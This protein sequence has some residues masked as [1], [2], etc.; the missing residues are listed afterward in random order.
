MSDVDNCLVNNS[1]CHYIDSDFTHK[2]CFE[3]NQ[4]NAT[5]FTSACLNIRSIVNKDHFNLF[6]SWIQSLQFLPDI[7]AIN[8]TWEKKSS[9]GQFRNLQH[10]EYISNFRS[11]LNGGGVALYIKKTI[12][13]A[14]RYD[15]SHMDEGIFESLF[16]DVQLGKDKI[17][18]STI[19]RS[20]KQD[21]FSNIQF[22]VQLNNV[23]NTINASKNKAY[24]MG[25][26]NYDL[27]QDSHTFTDNFVDTMYDHSFYPI[28]NKPTRITQNSSTCIDHIWTNIHDKIIKSA[29]ITHKIAD[30]LPVVQS[31]KIS[32]FKTALPKT[33]YFSKQNCARFIR[34]LSE[35]DPNETLNHTNVDDAMD[36]FMQQY[37]ILFN[38]HFPL[39]KKQSKNS[40]NSWFTNELRKLLKK[41]DR[42]YKK[43]IKNKSQANRQKYNVARNTYFHKIVSE[44]QNY[45]KNLFTIHKNDIKKTW[46]SINL[47]LGKEKKTVVL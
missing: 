47:L 14:L 46:H 34:A 42:M 3:N 44:K 8:E 43:Y 28:I 13:Y 39:M 9:I 18:C 1:L 24:I 26:L 21:K 10:Y 7:I 19:Y 11:N 33:R 31:T 40:S 32:N 23:L 38:L 29:I 27:L 30:H 35:I 6:E 37:S 36:S 17:T 15:L 12:H 20:P 4:T 2:F 16:I 41:K 22:Q 5:N 25:D 45:F